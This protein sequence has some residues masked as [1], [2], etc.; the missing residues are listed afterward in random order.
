MDFGF[1]L[2]TQSFVNVHLEKLFW[3]KLCTYKKFVGGNYLEVSG[4]IANR[5]Q[6]CRYHTRNQNHVEHYL[7]WR[8]LR[9]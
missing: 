5:S 9:K 1:E 6:K 8:C 4:K 7:R 3:R 2:L